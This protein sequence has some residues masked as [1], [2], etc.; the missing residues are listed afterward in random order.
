MTVILS[1]TPDTDPNAGPVDP[2][3]AL[4]KSTDAQN[5]MNNVQVPRLE[6][7]QSLADHYGSDP[8]SLS[9]KVRKRFREVKKIEKKQEAAD[10]QV[11]GRYGLPEELKLTAETE[12]TR[13]EAK[14]EWSKAQ[15]ELAARESKRRKLEPIG[16]V[17]RASTSSSLSARSTGASGSGRSSAADL[18]R[19]R[20]L[21]NTARRTVKPT[22]PAKPLT[23]R[24]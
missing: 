21:Q 8:Y 15:K 4:E 7:I 13:L 16:L 23:L 6:A 2:L 5:H 12:E 20:I 9:V 14:E 19:A 17:P 24:R 22:A 10:T 3:A 18:L 11:K 1:N